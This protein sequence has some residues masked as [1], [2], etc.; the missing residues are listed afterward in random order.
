MECKTGKS[1]VFPLPLSVASPTLGVISTVPHRHVPV[2]INSND[3]LHF[4]CTVY[5]GMATWEIAGHQFSDKDLYREQG[6]TVDIS[7]DLMFTNL[8]LSREGLDFL[9]RSN[10]SIR[11]YVFNETRFTTEF[12]EFSHVV[13]YGMSIILA[14]NNVILFQHG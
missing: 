10:L 6:V 1:P 11:C 4:N 12:G 7:E 14:G 2:A 8:S 13:R 3:L 9:N 5:G